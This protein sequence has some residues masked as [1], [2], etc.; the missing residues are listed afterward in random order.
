MAGTLTTKMA[1]PLVR[2]WEQMPEPKWCVAM[3]DCTCSGGRYKRSYTTVQGI[4]RVMP[5]DVYVPGCPPRPEGLIYGMMKLQQLVKERRGHWPERAIGPTV[6]EEHLTVDRAFKARPR[7]TLRRPCSGPVRQRHDE[8]EIRIAPGRRARRCMRTLHD[9]PDLRFEYLADLCRRGHR[10]RRSRSSTTSGARSRRTGC[11]SSP[12]GSRATIRA[13]PRSPSSG[14]APSG[15]SARPTTCSASSSRATATCAGSTCRPT[16]RAS[17]CA[18][19]STSPTTPRARPAAGSARWSS[20]DAPAD[21][22]ATHPPA[23][24]ARGVGDDR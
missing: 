3:G 23:H 24:V 6:P 15:W 11:G 7:G 19:T 12:T 14:R 10:R 4:D 2:L 18:R 13:S 1:G 9:E 5:V 8:T 20:A 21:A 16:S 17:R 22:D